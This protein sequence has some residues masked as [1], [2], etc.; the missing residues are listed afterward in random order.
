MPDVTTVE[1]FLKGTTTRAQV[2]AIAQ[3][4]LKTGARSA[5]VSEDRQSWIL[6]I[7][8]FE[9]EAGGGAGGGGLGGTE[10][11]YPPESPDDEPY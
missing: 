9:P 10:R 5:I 3:S 4:R 6:T 1:R 7:V 8:F 2:E 11:D